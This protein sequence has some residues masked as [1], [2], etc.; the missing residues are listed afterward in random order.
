M[1]QRVWLDSLLGF[2]FIE[3]YYHCCRAVTS[4][5]IWR[6]I[7]ISWEDCGDA[8][9]SLL[10]GS[11]VIPGQANARHTLSSFNLFV[12]H[13][14]NLRLVNVS[15]EKHTAS[16]L[17]PDTAYHRYSLLRRP[18]SGSSCIPLRQMAANGCGWSFEQTISTPLTHI[19]QVQPIRFMLVSFGLAPLSGR[20]DRLTIEITIATNNL[21]DKDVTP[22]DT[23]NQ[24]TPAGKN[25]KRIP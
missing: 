8:S 3:I 23:K 11:C 9:L 14:P 5:K 16:R 25:W 22:P 21:Q 10:L 24:K 18:S 12:T 19:G 6:P 20:H 17:I 7:N 1:V 13:V 2:R 15:R 4:S